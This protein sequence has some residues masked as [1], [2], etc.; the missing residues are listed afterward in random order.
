MEGSLPSIP[1]WAVPDA[2]KDKW[3]TMLMAGSSDEVSQ[4]FFKLKDREVNQAKTLRSFMFHGG[5]ENL[6]RKGYPPSL[7]TQLNYRF[8]ESRRRATDLK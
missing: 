3:S 1:K 2:V 4:S 8:F 7:P 6:N 5:V